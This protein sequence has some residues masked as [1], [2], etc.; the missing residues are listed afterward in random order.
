MF[1]ELVSIE[2][3]AL[4]SK[5]PELSG[6]VTTN[7]SQQFGL[8]RI[9]NSFGESLQ[10][11]RRLQLSDV[12]NPRSCYSSSIE[13]T[14]GHQAMDIVFGT[15]YT[16]YP[17]F[18]AAKPTLSALNKVVQAHGKELL[19]KP[20]RQIP[21]IIEAR[22]ACVPTLNALFKQYNAEQPRLYNEEKAKR[23]A[24]GT[25]MYGARPSYIDGKAEFQ[26][27]LNSYMADAK[28]DARK[29]VRAAQ[30]KKVMPAKAPVTWTFSRE[31]V[32]HPAGWFNTYDDCQEG[33]AFTRRVIIA[34]AECQGKYTYF[35]ATANDPKC[36]SANLGWG[37]YDEPHV[38]H[39]DMEPNSEFLFDYKLRRDSI[40]K[41][42]A[43]NGVRKMVEVYI[44]RQVR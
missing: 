44:K 35:Y 32:R 18:Q 27:I 4:E 24:G 40:G 6:S 11:R 39:W 20:W 31:E 14:L 33:F 5:K 10:V 43:E 42:A 1:R 9:E 15:S 12:Q 38:G 3:T 34:Q 2:L 36:L 26:R 25:R 30:P 7:G 23:E 19:E 41:I 16:K 8:R 22:N 17:A 13:S 21:A 37:V 29:V 28:K